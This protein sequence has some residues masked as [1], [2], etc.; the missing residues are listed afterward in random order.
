ILRV[1]RK[2]NSCRI[3]V[4]IVQG[5]QFHAILGRRDR[6]HLGLFKQMDNDAMLKPDT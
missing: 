1:W 3:R 5:D 2:D 4:H 6:V